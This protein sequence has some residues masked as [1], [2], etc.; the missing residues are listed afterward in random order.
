VRDFPPG[1]DEMDD[2]D[3]WDDAQAYIERPRMR[4]ESA[5]AYHARQMLATLSRQIRASL[6]VTRNST[7]FE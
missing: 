1:T 7:R 3:G 4:G 5:S 6:Q 2:P